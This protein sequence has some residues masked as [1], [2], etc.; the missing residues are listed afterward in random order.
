MWILGFARGRFRLEAGYAEIKYPNHSPSGQPARW[1]IRSS[2]LRIGRLT[3]CMVWV[4]EIP[5]P[6]TWVGTYM[7]NTQY[8]AKR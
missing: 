3:P 2:G 7:K 8:F 4:G 6:E 1:V 5:P